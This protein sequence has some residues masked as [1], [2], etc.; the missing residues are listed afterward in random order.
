MLVS[1]EGECD[2]MF[3]DNRWLNVVW[4]ICNRQKQI[5]Q[6]YVYRRAVHAV[7][8]RI[9]ANPDNR[10]VLAVDKLC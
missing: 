8:D 2:G 6:V 7:D 9:C 4:K 1:L 5:V 10:T 3:V